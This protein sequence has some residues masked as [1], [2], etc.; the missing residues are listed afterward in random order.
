MSLWAKDTKIVPPALI[1]GYQLFMDHRRL[2]PVRFRY[3]EGPGSVAAATWLPPGAS[4]PCLYLYLHRPQLFQVF[5]R[6]E[7]GGGLRVQ[8]ERLPETGNCILLIAT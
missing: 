8:A 4:V 1:F 2:P 7:L 6:I 5:F 3:K